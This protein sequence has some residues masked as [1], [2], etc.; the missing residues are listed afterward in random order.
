MRT[1]IAVCL[2]LLATIPACKRSSG[3]AL[4]LAGSTSIQ[5]FAEKWAEAYRAAH[6]DAQ[7]QV[8]GGGS[9]AGVQAAISGAA[10]IGTC[11]R[12]LKPEEEKQVKGILVARD[13]IA[14]VVHPSN[15]VADLSLEQVGQIYAGAI[16]NWSQ[17]G[18][19]DTKIALITRE[20]GSG[21]RGAFEDLV[22]NKQKIVASALVQDSTGAVRQMV[23][24][25][26]AAIGYI[27]LDLVDASVKALR[28]GGA[29]PTEAAID[30]GRYP[31]V[32]PFLFVVKGEPQGAAKAFIDWVVSP[33]GQAVTRKAGLLPP[34]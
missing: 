32:R 3:A 13:G 33:E 8:Q 30:A 22:M 15:P 17:V 20:E 1:C 7:I 12:A 6:P 16:T 28:L 11:S 10:Q 31:L 26:A 19:P 23:A 24:S 4:T 34:K 27:S 5:P 29:E 9:T 21:T 2:A 25:D 18:G 14:L